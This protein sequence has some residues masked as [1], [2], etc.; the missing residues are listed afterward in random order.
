MTGPIA[1][2]GPRCVGKTTV[3]R[4]IAALLGVPFTDLDEA[5]AAAWAR[6]RAPAVAA[7]PAGALLERLGEPAFR[8]L[9]AETLAS[10]VGAPGP[11]AGLVL[12]TGGGCVETPACRALLEKRCRSVW[13]TADVALLQRRLRADPAPRPSLTGADPALELPALVARRARHYRAVA[14]ARV[15]VD[16]LAPDAIARAV[17]A[18]L[19]SR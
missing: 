1:L 5:L 13:L 2:V 15:A 12:A 17:L 3:G 4:R 10:L 11:P 8:A 19:E 9:E 6:G 18:A 14:R 7:P 16:G